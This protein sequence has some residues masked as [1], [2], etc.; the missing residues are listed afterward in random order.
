MKNHAMAGDDGMK[1]AEEQEKENA[2]PK[3]CEA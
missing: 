3:A 2:K 1:D